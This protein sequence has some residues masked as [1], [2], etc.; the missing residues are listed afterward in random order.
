MLEP[1]AGWGGGRRTLD[2]LAGGVAVIGAS[3]LDTGTSTHASAAGWPGVTIP[4]AAGG[5]AGVVG[6]GDCRVGCGADDGLVAGDTAGG[7]GGASGSG[8]ARPS[9]PSLPSLSSPNVSSG[10][11]SWTVSFSGVA[12]GVTATRGG[13]VGGAGSVRAAGAAVW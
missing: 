13:F 1:H 11:A 2:S 9:L 5:V 3:L 12:T 6:V 4:S 7:A 10:G 8:V